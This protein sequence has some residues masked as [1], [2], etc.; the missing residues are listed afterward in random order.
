MQTLPGNT[1]VS[2]KLKHNAW[3]KHNYGN[4]CC[5]LKGRRRGESY[6]RS[7]SINPS[8]TQCVI[9]SDRDTH[10]QLVNNKSVKSDRQTLTYG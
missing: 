4:Q 9:Q 10:G 6:S 2:G 8:D 1:E 3:L 7:Q 5:S